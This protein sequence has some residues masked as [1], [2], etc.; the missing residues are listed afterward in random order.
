[1]ESPVLPLGRHSKRL[2]ALVLFNLFHLLQRALLDL[3]STQDI[4]SL[5]DSLPPDSSVMIDRR[6]RVMIDRSLDHV[7]G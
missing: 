4:I 3:R 5:W 6:A 1:M 2:P 7:S